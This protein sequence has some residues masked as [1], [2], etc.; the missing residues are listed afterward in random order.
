MSVRLD[1]LLF[2]ISLFCTGFYHKF[3]VFDPH[4]VA[5][6]MEQRKGS[7]SFNIYLVSNLECVNGMLVNFK[8]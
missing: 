7:V 3:L 6:V 1:N 5:D 4:N 8:K 2:A